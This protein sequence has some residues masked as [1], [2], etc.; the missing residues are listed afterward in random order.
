[1]KIDS[2]TC[3]QIIEQIFLTKDFSCLIPVLHKHCIS[4]FRQQSKHRWQHL[5]EVDQLLDNLENYSELNTTR[6]T[7]LAQLLRT[8]KWTNWGDLKNHLVSR[9]QYYL[10]EIKDLPS[11]NWFKIAF[12]VFKTEAI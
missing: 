4:V 6:F 9:K 5:L 7:K 1:L 10:F 8:T 12:N 11:S 3:I 2:N